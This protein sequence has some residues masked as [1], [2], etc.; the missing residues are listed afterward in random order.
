MSMFCLTVHNLDQ[1]DTLKEVLQKH[2]V[3]FTEEVGCMQGQQSRPAPPTAPLH[4]WEW[5]PR[6][7]SR[8]HLDFAGP[9]LG[10]MYLV[11]VDAHSKWLDVHIM[12]SITS[13]KT[14]E[15]L[16]T[17]FAIHGLPQKVVTDNGP[18]FV[19]AEFNGLAERAVQSFKQGI[20]L[21]PGNSIQEKLSKYLFKYRI[22]PH[23]TTGIAPAELLMNRR[24]RSKLDLVYPDVAERVG[25]RQLK[26]K[27]TH[28]NGNPVRNL[29]I[30]D[31]VY[32]RNLPNSDPKWLAGTVTKVTGPLSYHVEL[33]DGTIVRKYVDHLRSRDTNH[34]ATEQTATTPRAPLAGPLSV[35][36][37]CT[38]VA[39]AA[40]AEPPPPGD[41]PRE[42][43]PPPRRST[44]SRQP[45]DRYS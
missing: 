10:H 17:V 36:Y 24:L 37:T 31:K 26:Q 28:D 19:S 14:I 15:K 20:K 32:V 27:L 38:P 45:P 9:Y 30:G 29:N 39:D 12:Q 33:L 13:A 4:P 6:P 34:T 3:V 41:P 42:I 5:P 21:T 25:T 2:A 8:L 44:R 1:H 22:T 11:I 35:P 7:W 43:P 40:E 18:S 23:S 16:R